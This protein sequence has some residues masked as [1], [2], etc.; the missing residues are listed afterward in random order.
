MPSTNIFSHA[1]FVELSADNSRK[2][3]SIPSESSR[4]KSAVAEVAVGGGGGGGGGGIGDVIFR[5]VVN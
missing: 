3:L 5:L 2:R 1:D 4:E